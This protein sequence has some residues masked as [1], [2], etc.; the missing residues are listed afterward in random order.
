MPDSFD[1]IAACAFGLEA[2]VRRELE[3]LGIDA[4]IG[5]S[6][7]VHFAGNFETVARANLHLR[8]AD[9]VLIQVAQFEASDFDALFETVKAVRWGDWMPV[10]ASFP[11]TGRSI[12]SQLS[13]VPACQ[14]SVKRAIVDAMQRDHGTTEL[15][16][17]G[18]TFKI[19]IALLKDM[20]TLTIDT[21]G[22]SLHRRGYRTD[23][24][25][26]PLKET[27]AAAM[28][29]LS[30]WKPDRP[31]IDPFCGSGTIPIEAARIGRNIAPGIERDF[32]FE[33]WPGVREDQTADLRSQAVAAQV[34]KLEERILG[35]DID[36]RVLAAARDNAS[37][38]GVSNDIHFQ[39][40]DACELSN[41]RRFGCLITN[42]PYGM[43]LGEDRELDALYRSLPDVLR[44]LPTWSHYFLTAYPEFESAVGRSADRR[45]K[46]YNGRIECT[47]FQFHGPKR[48]TSDAREDKSTTPYAHAS[49]DAA[50][51]QLDAKAREQADLFAVRLKKRAKHLRRWPTKRG[52]TCFRL[53]E[54]DIPEI[55]LVV[56]R[57]EDY[58]HL[59]E[60]ERPHDRDPAQHANWLDLMASTAA[61][62]LEV[63][64]ENVHLKRRGRQREH[65]QHE[66]VD[67]SGNRIV[68]NEGGLKF[69]VN[70]QDYV[71]T[72]LFLDH[73]V[74]R[75]MVRDLA[76]DKWFLNLFAY[77][78]SFTVY[79]SDGGARKTTSV[80][81]S[82]TY[83]SW[84]KENLRLNGF[85]DDRRQD[86]HQLIDS[87]VNEFLDNHPAGERYDLV[88]FD[89]PTYSRS[90]KTE[91]DWNVQTDAL[92]M[93]QK[94][95]PLVRKGG[96]IFFSSNFRRF[97]FDAAELEVSEC[98]EISKQTVPEDFRNRRI[99]R[100]WRIVR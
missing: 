84:T 27:L 67:D 79:A 64:P 30:F 75:S 78:G 44:G 45:R 47:Y 88:V 28:V 20:A 86:G 80:D 57:Y 31:L 85:L 55:P 81:L 91:Q 82:K 19:D 22:R 70:L 26:A 63:S 61:E 17:S 32:T 74:T 21:T 65:S 53:Y 48:V 99:H 95:L 36:G 16:E 15:A 77:T 93:L 7:R 96:V 100:C 60:Y 9:R 39:T 76:K 37:R 41:K 66:K 43:R 3:G 62:A 35:S 25:R 58:L 90:K 40:G 5:E 83:T 71:D 98:H 56:D 14:R 50:F 72:G 51:G 46:L 1:L 23:V 24:S 69:W 33:E 13:S 8:C 87:D 34:D 11:V 12:K 38:A 6:G 52:I 89:P 73:R 59:S 92:P 29:L 49:G 10:D 94:L 42:P 18:P 97:K 2:I 4:S 54:R 68:V